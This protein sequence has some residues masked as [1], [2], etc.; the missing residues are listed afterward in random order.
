M[1]QK[2]SIVA[3]FL[4]FTISGIKAQNTKNKK[5]TKQFN[6]AV[7]LSENMDFED[8]IV[9][10]KQILKKAPAESGPSEVLR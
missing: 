2:I 4:L 1:L 9:I 10:F 7:K 6:E 3:I 8:A 5:L